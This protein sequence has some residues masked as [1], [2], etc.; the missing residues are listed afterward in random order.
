MAHGGTAG[1]RGRHIAQCT[2][3]AGLA[4]FFD[5]A[6][7][8][9]PCV[10]SLHHLLTH[11]LLRCEKSLKSACG[12]FRFSTPRSLATTALVRVNGEGGL[13]QPLS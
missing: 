11:F 10:L 1:C 3:R 12:E 9:G 6:P 7:L 8:L 5:G 13:A 4:R 2:N